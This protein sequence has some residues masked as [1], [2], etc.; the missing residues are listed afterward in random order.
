MRECKPFRDPGGDADRPVDPGRDH[1]VDALGLRQ[2]RDPGLVL[3]R[4][5]RAAVREREP[6][7]GRVAIDRDREEVERPRGLEQAELRRARA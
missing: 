2:L 5:D 7:G 6:R 1:A 3:R 4:E